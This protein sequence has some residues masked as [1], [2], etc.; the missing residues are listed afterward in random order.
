MEFYSKTDIGR[1]RQS[2]QDAVRTKSLDDN[3]VWS[4]V[5]DGMGGTNGGE[6]A[7]TTAINEI[8]NYLDFHLY[9]QGS[10]EKMEETLK[11]AVQ[12]ANSIIFKYANKSK[13]FKK[14]GTTVV[15][16][17]VHNKVLHIAYAGDSRAYIIREN[18]IK[19]LTK[20]HSVVQQMID[21][22]EITKQDA[23][24]HPQ[25]NIITRAVGVHPEVE[26]DCIQTE[27]KSGDIILM[28]TDGLT[29]HVSDENICKIC[30]KNKFSEVANKL[31]YEA[32]K[33][34]GSDNIT[35]SVI[36]I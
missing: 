4:A 3:F 15:L 34:G 36:K 28:C 29:N 22:G 2:N 14:M 21:S 23:K 19:Q 31:I 26:V 24:N 10:C 33:L 13:I 32:N 35:V 8:A 17:A 27:L 1:F 18:Q 7:S 11:N 9:Q 30:L 12:N 5:C 25:K 6:I 16:G 20:D